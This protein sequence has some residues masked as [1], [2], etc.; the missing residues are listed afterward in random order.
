M[1]CA[2]GICASSEGSHPMMFGSM[3]SIGV[4][5]ALLVRSILIFGLVDRILELSAY[6]WPLMVASDCGG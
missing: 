2:T 5:A 4:V 6:M 1:L 3:V